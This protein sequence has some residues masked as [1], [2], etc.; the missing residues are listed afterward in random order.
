MQILPIAKAKNFPQNE[1][2]DK[3]AKLFALEICYNIA[4]HI[5]WRKKDNAKEE[6]EKGI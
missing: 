3:I 5:F 2:K 6:M 1:K 4:I